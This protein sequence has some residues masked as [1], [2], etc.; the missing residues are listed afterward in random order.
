MRLMSYVTWPLS[1]PDRHSRYVAVSDWIA[2]LFQDQHGFRPLVVWPPARSRVVD[3][4]PHDRSG[5]L[6]LSRLVEAKHA[7]TMLTL[8]N[9]YPQQK[10]TIAGATISSDDPY[11]A[12]LRKRIHRDAL[13]NVEIVENPSDQCVAD[14][15]SSHR[16]FVFPAP[17]EHFGIVTVEA[18]QAG[19]LPIVHD[20]GGQREIVPFEQLRFLS[21]D[22]LVDRAGRALCM[23]AAERLEILAD[24]HRHVQ[25]GSAEHYREQML[26]PLRL[27][28]GS[29][30]G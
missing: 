24:L 17:W 29:G 22:E 27:L 7:H 30:D 18:I 5:F 23:P 6:F 20:T 25:R 4:V 11:V 8:A 14:L 9:A 10:V 13:S 16:Y 12:H 28:Q 26:R 19:L 3:C 21:D 15:L 2:D 1:K